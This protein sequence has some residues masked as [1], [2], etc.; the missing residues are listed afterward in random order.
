M[1]RARIGPFF[2]FL[3]VH[4]PDTVKVFLGSG[5]DGCNKLAL[6]VGI[7]SRVLCMGCECNDRHSCG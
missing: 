5:M 1:H 6:D 4:H 3:L 7:H 2:N